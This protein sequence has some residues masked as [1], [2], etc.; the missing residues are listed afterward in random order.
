MLSDILV[1]DD[2][3]DIRQLVAGILEDEGHSTRLAKNSQEALERITERR[4]SLIFLDIWLQDSQH[5]G[6]ELLDIINDQH[7]NIPVVM[8]SGHG[9]IETAVSAIKRAVLTILSKSRSKPTASC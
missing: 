7:P 1:V 5:D 9:N 2:E 6:L 3:V 4:P 8:I